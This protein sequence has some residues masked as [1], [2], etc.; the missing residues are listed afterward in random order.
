ML[1][2]QVALVGNS[3]CAVKVANY[4]FNAWELIHVVDGFIR[5]GPT[6]ELDVL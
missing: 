3:G 2:S 5:V 1:R 4:F 6:K